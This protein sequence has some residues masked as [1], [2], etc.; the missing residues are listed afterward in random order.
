MASRTETAPHPPCKNYFPRAVVSFE[1]GGQPVALGNIS[2]E[3][4]GEDIKVVFAIKHRGT[5]LPYFG[6]RVKFE[7]ESVASQ[8]YQ[9]FKYRTVGFKYHYDCF[10]CV[11]HTANEKEKE[12]FLGIM[13]NDA[14]CQ[15]VVKNDKLYV[16]KLFKKE[17]RGAKVTGYESLFVGAN[18]K[19]NDTYNRLS[20]AQA[21]SVITVW[22]FE[23]E[24]LAFH[25][26]WALDYLKMADQKP[27]YD[28]PLLL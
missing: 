25:V 22:L 7:W 15:E 24:N 14:A 20:F 13:F 16:I 8:S 27:S 11:H 18:D 26:Q 1:S 21:S 19:I 17:N 12:D 5:E 9:N 28:H 6:F 3:S 10:D 23:Y 4:Q 2:R